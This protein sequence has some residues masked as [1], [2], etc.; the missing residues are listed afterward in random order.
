MFHV[1]TLHGIR[2]RRYSLSPAKTWVLAVTQIYAGTPPTVFEYNADFKPEL[3][4]FIFPPTLSPQAER[5]RGS[6]VDS[7]RTRYRCSTLSPH[8]VPSG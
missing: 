6:A 2:D 3:V 8:G 5:G 1:T 4:S 7:P